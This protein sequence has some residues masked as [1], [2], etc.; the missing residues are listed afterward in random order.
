MGDRRK[1]RGYQWVSM[2][3]CAMRTG[4]WRSAMG[5]S[6]GASQLEEFLAGQSVSGHRGRDFGGGRLGS[7]D[8]RVPGVQDRGEEDTVWYGTVGYGTVPYRYGTVW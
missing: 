7:T 2:L 5:R 8:G 1:E 4:G 6:R 3:R